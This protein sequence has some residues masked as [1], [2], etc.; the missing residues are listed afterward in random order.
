MQGSSHDGIVLYGG[1]SLWLPTF[2][3]VKHPVLG[4]ALRV[5]ASA[6]LL[7]YGGWCKANLYVDLCNKRVGGGMCHVL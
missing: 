4:C 3:N 7:C 5:L 2:I 1:R 6:W